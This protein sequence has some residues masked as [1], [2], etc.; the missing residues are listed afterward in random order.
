MFWPIRMMN[1]RGLNAFL[2]TNFVKIAGEE[3]IS[4]EN[5]MTKDKKNQPDHYA[6]IDIKP[7]DFRKLGHQ[8]IDQ[9]THFLETLPK[10]GVTLGEKPTDIRKL[11]GN[12]PL[13]QEGTPSDMLLTDVTNLIIE[14]SLYNGHPC[15]WGYITS[16]AA[17]IGALGDLVAAAVNPNVGAW[18]L[19]P[20]ASEIESQTIDWIAQLI[21]Y[22][23]P[24][25]GLLVSGG[26][27]ANFVGFLVA[28]C[29]KANWDI[30]IHG[31]KNSEKQLTVYVSQETHTW[32]QKA[33]DLF[34]LGTESIRWI[35]VDKQL[36][37]DPRA[38][39]AQIKSDRKNGFYPFL[40]VGTAGT[41]GNG[42][43]DPLSEISDICKNNE[44]WFHVDGAYGAPA[45][46][47]PEAT[48]QLK[49]LS[50]ADSVA[51][52]PHKWLYTPLEAGCILVRNPQYLIET[53]S[54][55]PEYYNFDQIDD[56]AQI[57]YY[58]F[59]PQNSR[60]FRALKVWLGLRQVGRKGYIQ[61]IRKDI[62]LAKLLYQNLEKYPE[63]EAFTQ[64]LSITTFRFKPADLQKETK[65]VEDYL[66]KLNRE[67]LNQLQ[68]GGEVFVS[69]AIINGK[70]VLRTCIVN[71]R[72]SKKD[73]EALPE[74][75]I[76][77]GKSVDETLR[78]T[79]WGKNHT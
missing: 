35:P 12:L 55:H 25:A 14:H 76:R 3:K 65:T 64:N 51:V 59:G 40:V 20:V 37:M 44:L 26:N 69:N 48:P 27:M 19:S 60:G 30:R 2:K 47:L 9:I 4:Q 28:R 75:V 54:F 50:E 53:F 73:I 38:L 6:P 11:L 62:E 79:E 45:A 34:G 5:G 43:I 52:D 61:M 78:A 16:S 46:V 39:E 71:F 74:I 72:T 21:G 68:V 63:L 42:A 31:L 32:I 57:N 67:L 66:D 56:D 18:L 22:P 41:V 33:T 8:V 10:R 13:P 36:Q 24:C 7:E 77:I 29:M 58:E 49:A 17:P 15:F 70:F 1:R 23:T